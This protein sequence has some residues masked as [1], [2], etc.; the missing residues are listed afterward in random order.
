MSLTFSSAISWWARNTPDTVAIHVL[1]ETISYRTYDN[2]GDRIAARLV[3]M[4]VRPGD[5]VAICAGNS[6]DYCALILGAI[7]AGAIV[8]PVSTRLTAHEIGEVFA[9][10]T[11]ARAFADA[12]NRAKLASTDVAVVD[13]AEVAQMRG[14]AA[15]PDLL[16]DAPVAIITTSGSTARPKG[17]V[18][19]HRSMANAVAEFV[20]HLPG[21]IAPGA[22]ALTC[23]PLSTSAG[24]VQL[25]T[26][27]TAGSTFYL[28][29]AFDA[30]R[31]LDLIQQDRIN[32]F[33]GAPIFPERITACPGFAEADL[34][35]LRLVT[36]GG[37]AVS[38]A[39][40]DTWKQKGVIIRQMYGQTEIG[41]YATVMPADRAVDSPE[42]CG[43][44]GIF[45]DLRIV[46]DDGKFCPP[47]QPGEIVL[48]GPGMML[49]YWNNP[50]A[51]AA[52]I[53]DG[54]LY[55]GDIGVLDED[56]LL[57]FVDRKKD[58]IISGGLNISAAEVESVILQFHDIEEAVVIAAPDEKFGETPLAVVHASRAISVEE[59]IAHCNERLAAYK[60][61]RYLV[62]SDEPLPRLATGKLSKVALR[63]KYRDMVATLP[64][65]R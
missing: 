36:V 46:G 56:G 18:Y 16:P 52:V 53:R 55:T 60:V 38:R 65:V 9:D 41:G 31:A 22:R 27:M 64:R 40:L 43:R 35:S 28:E 58:I 12:A 6:I 24:F 45:T 61:P 57:T 5:R 20:L 49:G 30:Q 25:V 1:G 54:W 2:R 7:R 26:Y 3:E 47:G 34:S 17:V 15:L 10:T 13:I 42:K 21:C 8:L 37:A 11:P 50:E 33:C 48:R 32:V 39:L 29:P 14:D 51:T 63:E 23:A 44:G 62:L 59:I 19:S 4:G